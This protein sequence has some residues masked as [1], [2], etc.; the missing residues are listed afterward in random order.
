MVNFSLLLPAVLNGVTTGAIYALIALGLTLIYGVLHIINFAHGSL[1]MLALYAAF[2]L[3]TLAGIDPYVAVLILVPAFF[4]LGY[5]LQRFVIQPT[6]HGRDENI[7]LVT[8]GL[9]II[10]DN[11]ALWLWTSTTRTID[12]WYA[13]EV[14]DL[15]F[16]FIPLP[17]VIAFFGA[18]AFAALLWA[19]ITFTD[20][21]RAI[22]AVARERDGARLVGIRVEHVYAMTFGIGTAAVAAAACFLLPTFYV[23][24]QVGYAFVL[25][26]FTTVVLGGMGSF[27]GALSAG[28]L[29][30][31]V[32]SLGGLYLGESLGQL[33]IFVIFILILLFRP[34]GLFGARA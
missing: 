8:L 34:M 33:G 7:L 3:Y 15:G 31:I 25:V 28:L 32:E 26:A 1:L 9:A 2:F 13:F 6:S 21:G 27:V 18:L 30:G 24:P 22:R 14:V 5:G 20:L 10:I 4:V 12:T 17:K 11:L 19:L 16:A 23:T 29:L